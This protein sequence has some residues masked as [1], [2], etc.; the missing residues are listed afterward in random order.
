MKTSAPPAASKLLDPAHEDHQL[1]FSLL[2]G[3]VWANWNGTMTT[4]RLGDANMVVA[5]MR[6]FLEQCD[7]AVRLGHAAEAER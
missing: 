4:V 1:I 5:T 6:E 3:C 2:D 7:L